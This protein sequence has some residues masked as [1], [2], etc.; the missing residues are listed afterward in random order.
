MIFAARFIV[1]QVILAAA[2]FA[3]WI[4]GIAALPFQGLSAP[5][6][7]AV[8]IAFALGMLCIL[9]KRFSDANWIATRILRLG[10]LGTVVGLVMAFGA[11]GNGI[12]A[13]PDAART[14]IGHVIEGMRVALYVTLF[15]VSSS[16]WL[17]L[18]LRLLHD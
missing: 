6:C 3:A 11:A 4:T 14:I 5:F 1:L 13:D 2:I 7:I 10:L 9:L 16:L 18:N 17:E 12:S 15:G 8:S